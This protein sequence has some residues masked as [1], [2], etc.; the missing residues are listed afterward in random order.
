[1]SKYIKKQNGWGKH[2][3]VLN[4]FRKSGDLFLKITYESAKEAHN[5]QCAMLKSMSHNR[6]YDVLIRRTGERLLLKRNEEVNRRDG[7][8]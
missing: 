6:V 4:E 5:A 8:L 3:E 2:S 1:M 7:T